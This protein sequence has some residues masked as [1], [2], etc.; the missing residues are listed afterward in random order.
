M[1]VQ[2]VQTRVIS[3]MANLKSEDVELVQELG[4]GALGRVFKAKYRGS[5]CAAKEI[6]FVFLDGNVAKTRQ[7]EGKKRQIQLQES[8]IRECHLWRNL[9]HPNIVHFI[10]TY[11]SPWPYSS[12]S[13]EL[14]PVMIM[15]LMDENLTSYV[16]KSN[17]SFRSKLSILQDIADGISY[18]HSSNSP[19]T[20]CELTPYSVFIKHLPEF[21]VAKISDLG[22]HIATKIVNDEMSSPVLIYDPKPYFMPPESF[23]DDKINHDHSFDVF[24]YG[25]ITL[26]ILNGKWPKPTELTRYDPVTRRVTGFTEVERRQ[27]HLDKMTGEAEALKSLVEACLDNDPDSR[28]SIDQFHKKIMTLQVC[29]ASRTEEAG[30]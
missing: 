16:E 8:F 27:E 9:S 12:S 6:H 15:E 21:P 25:G 13:Q 17:I 7:G 19:V 18:L 28:P 20:H 14:F 10:G 29:L 1:G 5:L 4:R 11:L 3:L 26:Y 22:I 2:L 23:D 24:S 30:M